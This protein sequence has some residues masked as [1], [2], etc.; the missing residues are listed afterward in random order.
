[1]SE[2]ACTRQQVQNKK[3]KEVA[4]TAIMATPKECTLPEF[5]AR[6]IALWLR[7]VAI[8]FKRM[9]ITS[10]QDRYEILVPALPY[11]VA[12]RLKEWI[13]HTPENRPYT[14]ITEALLKET[15][16]DA[17]T[18][19]KEIISSEDLRGD[20][21]PTRFLQELKI[22]AEGTGVTD[23]VLK[24]CFLNGM[25]DK[26]KRELYVAKE[27]DLNQMAILADGLEAIESKIKKS[28]NDNLIRSINELRERLDEMQRKQLAEGNKVLE[29]AEVE[30]GQQSMVTTTNMPKPSLRNNQYKG[31]QGNAQQ[32]AYNR[33]QQQPKPAMTSQRMATPRPYH[34]AAQSWQQSH[35]QMQQRPQ[36]RQ[37]GQQPPRWTTG[38]R[39]QYQQQMQNG[40]PTSYQ[41]N[42]NYPP[43][44]QMSYPPYQNVQWCQ[45]QG[46]QPAQPYMQTQAYQQS[47]NLSYNQTNQ[48]Q[49]ALPAPNTTSVNLCKHHL[50]F[51]EAATLCEPGCTYPTKRSNP[52][53]EWCYY[54]QRFGAKAWKCDEGCSYQ[55]NE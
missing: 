52:K 4:P 39:W 26:I 29:V 11:D 53:A 44:Q 27:D 38:N 14:T 51:G 5:Q 15:T 22:R 46:N 54:H 43:F 3:L 17:Q 49:L 32:Q 41:S 35:Q 48:D 45:Q 19:L 34:N 50:Q 1:M 10:E 31:K 8:T 18:R 21:K 33:P 28:T 36:W 9:N 37:W 23:Q 13:L 20:L 47:Q 2:G 25:D 24:Q 6:N 40:P 42:Q 30:V 55:G 7:Q 12:E 16:A